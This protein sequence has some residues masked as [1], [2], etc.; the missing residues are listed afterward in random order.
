MTISLNWVVTRCWRRAPLHASSEF[1]QEFAQELSVRLPVSALFEAPT[2]AMLAEHLRRGIKSAWPPRVIPIQPAG[3]PIPFWAIGAGATFRAVAQHL[4]A[5]QPVSG[6]LLEDS[7]VATLGPPYRVETISKEIVR[8]MRQQQPRGPY[9]LGGH[10]LQGLFAF[11]AARQLVALGEEVRLLVL[12]D[13]Q[14]PSAVRMRFPLGLR[15]RVHAA[16]AW[17]LLE[18]RRIYDAV[19]FVFNTAKGLAT[20]L[21]QAP[22]KAPP[23]PSAIED[24][25]RLAAAG[26][27]PRPYSQRVVF[28]E[29]ADQP[30]ALHLGSRLGW[31]ELAAG[32]LEIQVV[33]GSHTNLLEGPQ[34][35][36][37]AQTL[38]SL[39]ARPAPG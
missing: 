30:V 2:V 20:R 19:G 17:W 31:A 16:S 25:L 29:A 32:G 11:E 6:L 15:V 39:L 14:L 1:A 37:V 9:Q 24:V 7:D 34:A 18:R 26:Y 13:T 38:A 21:R 4:G 8:L 3:A 36:A 27:D 35:P 5:D 33:P 23:L 12:F 28:L 22:E 10:S